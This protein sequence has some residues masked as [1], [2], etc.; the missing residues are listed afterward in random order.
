METRSTSFIA[1]AP[2]RH[3]AGRH[4]VSFSRRKTYPLFLLTIALSYNRR[5]WVCLK[6]KYL[7]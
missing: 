2:F 4:L 1:N 6:G 7:I 5:T 3:F